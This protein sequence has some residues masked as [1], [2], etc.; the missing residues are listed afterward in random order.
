[1]LQH[2]GG[3]ISRTL[4]YRDAF[5]LLLVR[6]EIGHRVIVAKGCNTHVALK[7]PGDVLVH[8]RHSLDG[9]LRHKKTM[10]ERT[11]AGVERAFIGL[12]VVSMDRYIR[13]VLARDFYGSFDLFLGRRVNFQRV[14]QAGHTTTRHDFGEVR[15]ITEVTA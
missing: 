3:G 5:E 14:V 15:T 1:M 4:A 10:L 8:P 7:A 2:H 11:N 9:L 12:I 13:S 6:E